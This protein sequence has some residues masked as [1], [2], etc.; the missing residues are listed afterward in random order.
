M[1]LDKYLS[2][3]VGRNTLYVKLIYFHILKMSY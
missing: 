1:P 2:R 3:Y